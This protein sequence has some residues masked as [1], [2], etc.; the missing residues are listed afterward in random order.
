MNAETDLQGTRPKAHAKTS[1]LAKLSRAFSLQRDGDQRERQ[2]AES[3]L[4]PFNASSLLA[5]PCLLRGEDHI[6]LFCSYCKFNRL[7]KLSHVG[8]LVVAASTSSNNSATCT[9]RCRKGYAHSIH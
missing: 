5:G 7:F 6:L 1:E 9:P 4:E 2:A 3:S 8:L